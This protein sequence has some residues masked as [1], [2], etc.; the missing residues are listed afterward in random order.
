M[1][2]HRKPGHPP[3]G[4]PGIKGARFA[5][6]GSAPVI[7]RPAYERTRHPRR[8]WRWVVGGKWVALPAG[9]V[10]ICVCAVGVPR[11]ALAAVG[12]V[13]VLAGPIA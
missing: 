11:L 13:R 3:R 8:H 1:E 6:C 4:L 9:R 5:R 2:A 12:Q 7:G 10:A